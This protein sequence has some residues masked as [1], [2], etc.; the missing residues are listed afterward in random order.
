MNITVRNLAC[1]G[2]LEIK[3]RCMRT[4]RAEG[5]HFSAFHYYIFHRTTLEKTHL[6]N[7]LRKEYH[8]YCDDDEHDKKM[9]FLFLFRN[10]S[11]ASNYWEVILVL[12]SAAPCR[13]MLK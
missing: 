10:F 4:N 12:K 8:Y 1:M 6:K 11:H 2:H 5:L 9:M 3:T 7:F 13:S